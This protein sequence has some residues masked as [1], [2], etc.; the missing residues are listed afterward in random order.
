M[1][2][3]IKLFLRALAP[4][5]AVVT[6]WLIWPNAWLAILA[7]HAQIL[8]WNWPF[9]H[10]M[11]LPRDRKSLILALPT[12]LVGP[13]LYVLLPLI[14]C[15]ELSTWL[16]TYQ[17]S[18]P[19]LVFMI[20]YFGFVH[21]VLEQIHWH[22]FREASD[23]YHPVFAGYHILV[24]SSLITPPWL[25]L[26]FGVLVGASLVWKRLCHCRRGL[27]VPVL[28][29]ILADLGVIVAAWARTQ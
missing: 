29:H 24:L 11:R 13:A 14:T 9:L 28:S 7:Y 25:I 21:P 26:C 17:L 3:N 23:W 16:D 19:A 2:E 15:T 4:Y 12:V 6:F 27:T 5:I 20:P 18:G 1:L 8:F 10:K 22:P